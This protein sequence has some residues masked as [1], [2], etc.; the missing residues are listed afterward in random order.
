MCCFRSVLGFRFDRGHILKVT[1]IALGIYMQ[2]ASLFVPSK[3]LCL[4]C[5]CTCLD[6]FTSPGCIVKHHLKWCC[7]CA[8]LHMDL[9]VVDTKCTSDD[10]CQ[11][12]F[13]W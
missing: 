1:V 13:C 9:L 12:F 11:V 4:L 6:H 10:C 5:L 7:V 2:V 8:G 3:S